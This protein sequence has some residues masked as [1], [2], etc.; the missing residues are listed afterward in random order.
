MRS[1]ICSRACPLLRADGIRSTFERLSMTVTVGTPP[2]ALS[3]PTL[4]IL[5]RDN[6]GQSG[7]AREY[8]DRR[9][10]EST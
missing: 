7:H 1:P 6:S 4:L 3:E 9:C 5:S 2:R 8:A 10:S